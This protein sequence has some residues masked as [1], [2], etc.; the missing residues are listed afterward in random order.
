MDRRLPW[1]P[2]DAAP[3]LE[4]SFA[5]IGNNGELVQ[6]RIIAAT[7]LAGTDRSS[8]SIGASAAT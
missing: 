1:S 3:V 5:R 7:K 8:R 6:E 4:P 2:D